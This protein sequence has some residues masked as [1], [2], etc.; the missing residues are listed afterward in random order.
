LR[1]RPIRTGYW[2]PIY[3][4]CTTSAIAVSPHIRDGDIVVVSEKAISTAKGNIVDEAS[5]VPSRTAKL[6][7]HFWMHIVWGYFLGPLCRFKPPTIRRLRSYPLKEGSVHKELVLR[8]AGLLHALKYGSEGGIDISN[9]PYSY[10]SLPLENAQR[11][12]ERL[13]GCIVKVTG[14]RVAVLISDTDSTFS[15]GN[16]HFTSRPRPLKGIRAIPGPLAFI[17]GR[18][19]RLQQRATPLAVAGL[20]LSVDSALSI[21]ERAHHTRGYGAGRTVWDMTERMRVGLSEVSWSMLEEAEHF[22]LVLVRLASTNDKISLP[23]GR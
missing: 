17:V 10:A 7:A 12:A 13:R 22:P 3:D 21:A 4:Y 8:H 19:L 18:A 5:I 20:R 23:S 2:R 16:F 6:L 11:E 15:F 1:T 9:V 14:R